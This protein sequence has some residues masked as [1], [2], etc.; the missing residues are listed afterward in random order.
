MYDLFVLACL[1]HQ[2]NNCVTLQDLHSPHVTHDKC[3]TRA[4]EIAKGMPIY[5]PMYFPKSYKCLDMT[6]ESK[7]I[8]T[9]WQQKV[10]RVD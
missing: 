2:P 5:M 4:Y 9:T 3:L 6:T 7:K 8:D 10:K 1:M